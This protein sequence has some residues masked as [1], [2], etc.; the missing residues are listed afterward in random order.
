MLNKTVNIATIL[1]TVLYACSSF[2][3][4]LTNVAKKSPSIVAVTLFNVLANLKTEN[5]CFG[6]ASFTRGS[7]IPPKY[8]ILS[9]TFK[10]PF[11]YLEIDVINYPNCLPKS[12]P[13][14]G[15][16]LI[17]ILNTLE[18]TNL[19]IPPIKSPIGLISLSISFYFGFALLMELINAV[20]NL[21]TRSAVFTSSLLIF[22]YSLIISIATK[23]PRVSTTAF[24]I[25]TLRPTYLEFYNV[26]P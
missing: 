5:F 2:G 22:D 25:P 16:K 11:K 13:L 9:S 7:N 12:Q 19:D 15:F 4:L 8:F 6:S 18:S 3:I 14:I 21:P 1:L 26:N 17:F 23:V 24:I 20:I 10:S